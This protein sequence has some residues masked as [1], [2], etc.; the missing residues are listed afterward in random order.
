MVLAGL[1]G[2]VVAVVLF[3]VVLAVA[4]SGRAQSNL[5]PPVFVVGPASRLAQTV[6]RTGP[7]LFP[8]PLN[9]GRDVYVQHLEGSDWKAFAARAPGA[10][11]RCSLRWDQGQAR[12]VDPCSG[13]TWP[14][15][16]A[17]LTAYPARVDDEGQLVVDLR[18][19]QPP[20]P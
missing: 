17:G 8:D 11:R 9:R 3:A 15:D 12:F 18:Q 10:S 13:D 4:R 14:A 19:P 2:V 20:A 5:G 16:G 7:L 6:E 1:A